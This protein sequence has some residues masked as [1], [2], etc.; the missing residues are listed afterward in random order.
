M[1]KYRAEAEKLRKAGY[2]YNMITNALGISKG[3]MSYWFKDKPFTP[4]KKVLERIKYG[5]IKSGARS[6][7]R[8]VKEIADLK[9]LGRKELGEISKRDLWL[10][11]LGLYI[12]EGSKTTESIRIINSD[13][14]IIITGIRWLR[15]I[16]NLPLNNIVIRLHIYPDTNKQEAIKF[17]RS[18]TDIPKKNFR[19]PTIDHRTDKKSKK[20]GKLPYGTAHI[21]VI[22][23]GD[24][25]KGVKLY[26]RIN[27]WIA[28][29]LN[30][31]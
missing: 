16:C 17:W 25:E 23:N 18:I 4:N 5:P 29:A 21:M 28:G 12:G 11:G 14:A 9:E 26:R 1:N 10:L 2:S 13:P 15:E 8:R 19:N 20:T 31:L 24:P 3:T 30:Q 6:H 22:T 7:N 27:G